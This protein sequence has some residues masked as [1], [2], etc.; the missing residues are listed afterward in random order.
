MCFSK[1]FVDS[2][3]HEYDLSDDLPVSNEI[4]ETVLNYLYGQE[5]ILNVDNCYE[6]MFCAR[7]LKIQC[8]YER[9][10][11]KIQDNIHLSGFLISLI[12]K[13]EERGDHQ[14]FR[15]LS[16]QTE[17]DIPA[18]LKELLPNVNDFES[19]SP[20]NLRK[21]VL[22]FL[23]TTEYNN[24]IFIEWLVKS[25]VKSYLEATSE[26]SSQEFGELLD[27]INVSSLTASKWRS[28]VVDKLVEYKE[29]EV[30]ISLFFVKKVLPSCDS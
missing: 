18:C 26:W 23:V 27:S 15:E 28:L 13:A 20:M 22:Q 9:S 10:L 5:V 24:S 16:G 14:I 2:E 17:G 6:I 1:Q 30:I 29:L 25:L 19:L 12:I 4:F 21:E 8:L 7:F 3:V 11:K